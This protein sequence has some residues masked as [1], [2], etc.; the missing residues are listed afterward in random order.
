MPIPSDRRKLIKQL[1]FVLQVLA[2][3]GLEGTKEFNDFFELLAQLECSRTLNAIQRIPKSSAMEQL[4]FDLPEREFKLFAR[5]DKASFVRVVSELEG[6]EV[7]RNTSRNTQ[8]DPWV[9]ILITLHR[10]GCDGNGVAMGAV[11]VHWG[12]SYGSVNNFTSRTIEAIL[13]KRDEEI[14]WPS[15]EERAEISDRFDR[16]HGLKGCVGVVDGTS[17]HTCHGSLGCTGDQLKV[18]GDLKPSND[19]KLVLVGRHSPSTSSCCCCCHCMN[20]FDRLF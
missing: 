13:S 14:H 12:Q 5:C 19:L 2:A 7:F 16:M 4:L 1:E 20:K 18:C 3:D 11:G 6:H 8:K 10:L 17:D 9:Q 15:P